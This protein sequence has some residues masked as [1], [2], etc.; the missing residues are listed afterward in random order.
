MSILKQLLDIED[1]VNKCKGMRGEDILSSDDQERYLKM[2]LKIDPNDPQALYRIENPIRSMITVKFVFR[3]KSPKIPN[4]MKL[5]ECFVHGPY[6]QGLES[7][8]AKALYAFGIL[9]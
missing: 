6:V 3:C 2:S 7:A 9:S 5:K 1:T 4:F 8:E